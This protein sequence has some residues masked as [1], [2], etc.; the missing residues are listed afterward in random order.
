[1]HYFTLTSTTLKHFED[2]RACKAGTPLETF[3]LNPQCCVFETNLAT[4]AFELVT[5]KKVLLMA[6]ASAAVAEEWIRTLR[7]IITQSQVTQGPLLD[8]VRE[9]WGSS[10]DGALSGPDF[11]EVKFETKKPLGLVLERSSEWAVVKLSN[12]VETG[13]S[14]GSVLYTVND[15]AVTLQAYPDTINT[16]TGW[17]PPLVLGFRHSPKK[18]GWLSKQSRGRNSSVKNWKA[19][20]FVLEGGRL[21]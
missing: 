20:Y 17:H 19:R 13:V 16:L 8:L 9:R 15:Q 7:R 6:A 4:N 2:E 21:A 10:M 5:S 14:V 18:R 3:R 11:Y 12:S 1:M